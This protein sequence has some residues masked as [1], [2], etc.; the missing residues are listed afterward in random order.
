MTHYENPSDGQAKLHVQGS[1]YHSRIFIVNFL[2]EMY[3]R[4]SEKAKK[5][6]ASKEVIKKKALAAPKSL[7]FACTLCDNE[8]ARQTNLAKHIAS[9]HT[10]VVESAA[11]NV[12][13]KT[14]KTPSYLT[15]EPIHIIPQKP[16]EPEIQLMDLT[17]SQKVLVILMQTWPAI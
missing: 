11:K 15:I 6:E 4:V 1:K 2:P 12:K 9:K 8:Y 16:A 14:K 10:K 17:E 7:S 3:K 5:K 13:K